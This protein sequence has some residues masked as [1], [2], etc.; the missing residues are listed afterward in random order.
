MLDV[1]LA[2]LADSVTECEAGTGQMMKIFPA[3]RTT[4]RLLV[5]QAGAV[6]LF[7]GRRTPGKSK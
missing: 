7:C 5:A 2:L 6:E 4:R 1:Q 3:I